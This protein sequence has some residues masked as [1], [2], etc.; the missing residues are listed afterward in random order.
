MPIGFND[1]PAAL[2]LPGVYIEFDNRLAGNANIDF[3]VLVIGQRLATGTVAEGVPT[4]VNNAS[5]AEEFFGRGSMLA[6]MFT[7]LKDA[8]QWMETWAI[9]LDENGAGVAA[10]GNLTVTG[11]A[12]ASGTVNAYIAGKRIQA[13]V[14]SGDD[15]TTI[16]AALAT[17]INS[18]TTLPVTAVPAAGTVGLTCNWNGETGND[19]DIRLN[20]YQGEALPKG[21]TIAIT[22]M[23]GG[24]ANPDISTAIAAMGEEWYN[25]VVMPFTDAANLTAL[26]TELD[27]RWG[28]MR[29]IGGRAFAAYRGN[30]AAT[31]TFGNTRNNPHI[32][33]MGTNI[34]PQPPYIWA[35]VNG[36]VAAAKLS[37]DPARP[38]QTLKLTGIMAPDIADR[39]TN[40]ERNLLLFDGIATYKVASDGAVMIERQITTYQL[41]ASGIAD[42]SYLDINTPETLERIRYKQRAL[43]AQK[44]PRHKLADDN[45]RVGAGQPVMQPKI[46]KM[47][48]LA[49]YLEME[50]DG[51]VQDYEGYKQ[52]L[53]T[54]IAATDPTRLDV[55]DSP[56]LV[57]QYRVHA[58]QVQFRR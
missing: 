53:L 5:E 23:N 16:A 49:L 25:W 58:Q 13:A 47:E 24:T 7:A 19:I 48:L 28:P 44:Y 50:A 11:A 32:T 22:N 10:T 56:Q 46:A 26:D 1:I 4:R 41:N 9:A 8:E 17:A 35:A 2:R 29:Q 34:A 3:K 43:F 39:W 33:C 36:L 27:S 18:D 57:G 21:V 30:H 55:Q 40:T 20:Y 31:G 52:S 37:I 45:A 51:W 38:V 15:A 14:S 42:D 6:E 12:T 54:E